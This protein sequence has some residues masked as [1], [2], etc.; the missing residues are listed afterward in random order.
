MNPISYD[1]IAPNIAQLT[2]VGSQ[3][4]V[5]WK[6]P[7]TGRAVGTSVANMAADPSLAGRVGASVKRSIA[8]E[9][10][11]G[12]ARMLSGL[13]GGSVGRVLTSAT[14]AAA[15]DLNTKA[16]SGAD[17]TQASREV[18]AVSAFESIKSSFAWDE[19][20]HQFVAR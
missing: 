20:R 3:V 14:Y 4:E 12:A 5:S 17:Y 18:A 15:A 9:V 7:A 13:I 19:A 16:T 8:N 6:C 1:S 10:I 11:Y 2:V